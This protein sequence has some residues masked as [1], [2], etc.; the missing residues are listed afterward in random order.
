MQN[1]L[2]QIATGGIQFEKLTG[3]E[4]SHKGVWK[5][6]TATLSDKE[7]NASLHIFGGGGIGVFGGDWDTMSAPMFFDQT[8]PLKGR[9]YGQFVFKLNER[10]GQPIFK[11]KMPYL[12]NTILFPLSVSVIYNYCILELSSEAACE[13]LHHA[14]ADLIRSMQMDEK[15]VRRTNTWEIAHRCL[16]ANGIHHTSSEIA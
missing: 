4:Y 13:K 8:R 6:V 12:L 16:N 1:Y 7:R 9:D 2:L 3:G 10:H 5:I 11:L 15:Y 14:M